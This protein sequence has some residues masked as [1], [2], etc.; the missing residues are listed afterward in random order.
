MKSI[1]IM[2]RWIL[3]FLTVIIF[4]PSNWVCSQILDIQGSYPDASIHLEQTHGSWYYSTRVGDSFLIQYYRP[5]PGTTPLDSLPVIFVMD[6]DMSFAMVY[7]VVRWLRWGREIPE[8]AVVGMSYGKGQQN[9]W[10]KRSRDYTP[11]QDLSNIWGDWPAAGGSGPF[12]QFLEYELFPFLRQEYGL[13]LRN[14]VFIGLSFA[15]LLGADILFSRPHLF[16]KYILAGPA[17]IWNHNEIFKIENAHAERSKSLY[18]EVF[19]AVGALDEKNITEPWHE[20][21]QIIN[22]REYKGLKLHTWVVE[23]ETHLSM[24]PATLTRGLKTVLK[25]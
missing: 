12:K 21:I 11:S 8:V 9:W 18:K 15:G 22:S 19:T 17:L 1:Y 2:N 3:V 25:L 5:E 10:Q 6:G 16:D 23:G 7:D 13:G 4:S 20:F 24:F 14:R